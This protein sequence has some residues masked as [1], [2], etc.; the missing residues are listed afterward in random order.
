MIWL[1]LLSARQ[2]SAATPDI[3]SADLV[4]AV[5]ERRA[6]VRRSA[7][8]ARAAARTP[9]FAERTAADRNPHPVADGLERDTYGWS[10]MILGDRAHSAAKI[11][12]DRDV[13]RK[14]SEHF[15]IAA[16]IQ[17]TVADALYNWGN[18]LFDLS[19]AVRDGAPEVMTRAAE[20]LL[21][22]AVVKYRA[23]LAIDPQ[24]S[25]AHNNLANALADLARAEYPRGDNGMLREAIGHYEAALRHTRTPDVV[26]NNFA[27]ALHDLARIT[28]DLM[29][30]KKS[31]VHFQ[32]AGAVNPNYYS[33]YL[34]WG[35]ALADLARRTGAAKT[36]KAAFDK[37]LRAAELDS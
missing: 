22:R 16:K 2:A 9:A 13:Y 4:P 24:L 18:V 30:F 26:H 28:D 33:V 35:H 20:A 5:A 37:Y 29:L 31:M 32:A 36:Y 12:D 23:A 1:T 34:S 3:A 15:V 8:L 25:D 19:M 11:D 7:Q 17:V 21:N 6:P 27:K 14:A 10:Q